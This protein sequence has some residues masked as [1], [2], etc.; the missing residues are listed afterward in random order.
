MLPVVFWPHWVEPAY[1]RQVHVTDH[2]HDVGDLVRGYYASPFAFGGNLLGD[3]VLLCLEDGRL[4]KAYR[5]GV[6]GHI[7]E[8]HIGVSY[9]RGQAKVVRHCQCKME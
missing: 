8:Y 3:F 9:T 1:N 6:D 2:L 4:M 5:R 7:A